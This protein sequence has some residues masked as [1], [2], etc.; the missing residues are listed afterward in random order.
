M[1]NIFDKN[2]INLGNLT[3]HSGGAEGSD[4]FFFESIGNRYGV[5][6]K[7]YSYKTKSHKS[8]SKVEISDSDYLEG[9]LE[10]K[11][12]NK[13]L[14]R[15]GIDR[16]MNLLARNWVQVKYSKQIFAIGTILSPGEKGSKG[17][18][19]N[20]KHQTVDGGTGYGIQMGINNLRDIY[21]FDQNKSSWY[22]W[23]YNS[24][25]FKLTKPPT[26]TFE[27][28]AGIGTRQINQNG[29]DAIEKLYLD[30]FS[31]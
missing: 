28:F 4:F 22:H 25:S 16:Y 20:A 2:P 26:I 9:V 19:S 23:D 15:Y 8:T 31:K 21:V 5:L 10:I 18:K 1:I 30:T 7:A 14:K 13:I 27:N 6:T 11:N 29:I 24:I 12:A 17:H 3:C